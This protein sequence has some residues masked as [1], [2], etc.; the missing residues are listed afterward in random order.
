MWN[1]IQRH[2]MP[3]AALCMPQELYFLKM[4]TSIYLFN[5]EKKVNAEHTHKY[6]SQIADGKHFKMESNPHHPFH[7]E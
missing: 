4:R 2:L 6:I 3:V 5:R 1:S 7:N